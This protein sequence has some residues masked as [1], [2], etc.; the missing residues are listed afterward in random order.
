TLKGSYYANINPGLQKFE[1]TPS[2]RQSHPEYYGENIWPKTDEKRVE[3][4]KQAFENLGGKREQR[5]IFKTTKARLL[6]YF[7]PSEGN[8]LP[9]DD[10]PVD[11]WC[12]FHLD[13]SLLTGLCSAMFL[14]QADNGVPTIVPSPSTASGLYIR[15]RG[16]ELTKV[17]IPADSLAFQ[18][19]EALELVTDG[20]L[21]ATP[22]CVRVGAGEGAEVISRETF[23]LF[24]QPDTN[25]RISASETFGQFSKRVFAEHYED[26]M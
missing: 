26:K 10:E 22:H 7:P 9:A 25:Q 18:T 1:I 3:G 2:Q 24:M 19:G 14:R 4:F 17:T 20:K 8:V 13:H 12:G 15:T 21:K 5:F 16:G 23:A 11:S 6:H